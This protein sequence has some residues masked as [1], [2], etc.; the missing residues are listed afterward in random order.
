M[1]RI[2]YLFAGPKR[3]RVLYTIPSGANPTG[4]SQ[5]RERKRQIYEIARRAENNLLIL[6]DDPYYYLQF[7]DANAP[8][9]DPNSN[10]KSARTDTEG[11]SSLLALDGMYGDGRVVRFDSFSKILAAGVRLGFCTAPPRIA[12]RLQLHMQVGT[13]REQEVGFGFGFCFGRNGMGKCSF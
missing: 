9:T 13:S 6:E 12:E 10:S 5:T 8:E 4:A 1:N 3:P 7:D 11:A 2:S